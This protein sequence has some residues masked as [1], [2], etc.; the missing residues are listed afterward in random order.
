MWQVIAGVLQ[1]VF[2]IIKNNFEKDAE[3]RKKNEVVY[4]E[5]KDA[6]KSRDVSRVNGILDRLRDK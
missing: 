3:K 2:L 6:L 4:V 5:A 1:I